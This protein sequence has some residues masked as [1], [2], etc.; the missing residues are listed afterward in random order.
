MSTSRRF[1]E[2][3]RPACFTLA[4]LLALL[5]VAGGADPSFVEPR[6][7]PEGYTVAGGSFYG[8]T[9]ADLDGDGRLDVA[10]TGYGVVPTLWTADPREFVLVWL[11]N[12]DGTF[13]PPV[14]VDLGP[15]DTVGAAG[16]VAADLDRDGIPDLAVAAFRQQ[17]IL[18]LLGR[19][20]G[21]FEPPIAYDAG[22]KAGTL[23]AADLDGDGNPDLA[24]A[25]AIG[26]M[27]MGATQIAVL[28][29]DGAGRFFSPVLHTV[30]Q[31]PSDLVLADADG[32]NGLDILV[33]CNTHDELSVLLNDGQ[34]GFPAAATTYSVRVDAR[35]LWAGDFDGDGKLDV[36]VAG[37]NGTYVNTCGGGCLVTVHGNGDGSFTAPPVENVRVT[38][39]WPARFYVAGSLAPDLN[40]DGR[41][42]A[43]FTRPEGGRILNEVTVALGKPGGGYDLTE[44]VASPGLPASPEARV[45]GAGTFSAAAGD[46]DGDGAPDLVVASASGAGAGAVSV[47]PGVAGRPGTFR[48]PRVVSLSRGWSPTRAL[49]IGRFTADAALDVLATTDALDT[50]P[51]NGDGTFGAAFAALARVAG[52]GEFYQ[53]LRAAD[54]NG[55][56]KLDALWLADDGVQG[57][58]APRHLVA[59]GNGDGTF[60]S[61]QAGSVQA[62]SPE[63][64]FQ[65]VNAVIADLDGNGAPDLAILT[66]GPGVV[67][68]ETWL[69]DGSATPTFTQKGVAVVQPGPVGLGSPGLAVADL[70]HDGHPDLVAHR[71]NAAGG[72]DL[73]FLRGN[74]DG[75]FAA[76]VVVSSDLASTVADIAVADVD[77]DGDPDL[78]V[79]P[80]WASSV[81]ILLGHGDGTF[82]AR[83]TIPSGIGTTEVRAADLDGDGHLD[84]VVGSTNGPA[85][86]RGDGLG[87]FGPPHHLAIGYESGGN[88]FEIGDLDGDGHPDL[89][90]GHPTGEPGAGPAFDYFTVLLGDPG[91][92]ANLAVSLAASSA[93]VHVAEPLEWTIT[94]ANHGPDAAS[95]V[96]VRDVLRLGAGFVS[97]HPT[98][99]SCTQG[100]GIVD[101][102]LGSMA[103]DANATITVRVSPTA[104]GTLW[105][106]A[107]ASSATVDPYGADD[108]ASATVAVVAASADLAL[109]VADVPD[110]VTAGET[111]AYTFT[112][113]NLGPSAATSVTLVETLPAGV[114]LV[115]A[116]P[117]QGSCETG[118]TTVTCAL[119][120]LD[121]GTHAVVVVTV[122]PEGTGM[123]ATSGTVS[124]AE[125]D[126]VPAND[127]ATAQTSVRAAGGSAK[128]GCGCG[129]AGGMGAALPVALLALLGRCG[130]S[131]RRTTG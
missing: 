68:V 29:G 100:D 82:G 2:L 105:S 95:S 75:T 12:G 3:L 106:G 52:P 14:A 54:L 21:T 47:L 129:T 112:A 125:A 49:A 9:I 96:A 58:P 84:L 53:T 56:G 116:A 13:Q 66:F 74:G 80:D 128:G 10:A 15:A 130:R 117:S 42:D 103:A 123:I 89:V 33:A 55:D 64:G 27:S 122:T 87:G 40:G 45:D 19:G 114:S 37:V 5:P 46:L 63:A 18:V 110:P 104:V 41:P 60:G 57:G 17:A 65:G 126:P 98:Q 6:L 94:V 71:L 25:P 115:S 85:F 7:L 111:L 88:P 120:G 83:S 119:G 121:P 20:D 77:E 50:V 69:N 97:A 51:G 70:D 59:L 23:Q 81:Q 76:A 28:R 124:A 38:G 36:L 61:A 99:G 62:L 90:A 22:V 72:D 48:A 44:W 91:P 43:F 35:G 127:T 8:V 39:E 73:L 31:F 108:A 67:H 93:E 24:I 107:S 113:T 92:R 131:A 34:G 16:I 86:H 79:A 30:S 102:A 26:E 78:L 4:L 1:P 118:S 11:G 101:C 32:K 109:T